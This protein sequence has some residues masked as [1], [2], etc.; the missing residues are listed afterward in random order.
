MIRGFKIDLS[1]MPPPS[2]MGRGKDD[3]YGK[4]DGGE[5]GKD[6]GEGGEDAHDADNKDA[7]LSA[8]SDFFAAGK[9]G[10]MEGALAAYEDL[11]DLC[12]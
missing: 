7:K 6:D 1:N 9:K 11:M 8:V 4:D 12:Q 10:D 2:K 5:Y 3:G